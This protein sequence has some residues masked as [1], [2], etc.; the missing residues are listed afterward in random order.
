[1]ALVGKM[2]NEELALFYFQKKFIQDFHHA[3]R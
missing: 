3:M 1:M 2:T